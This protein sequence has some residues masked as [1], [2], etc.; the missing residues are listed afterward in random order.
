MRFEFRY[1]SSVFAIC[2]APGVNGL[3]R[4]IEAAPNA[5][6]LIPVEIIRF[7]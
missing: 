2:S 7:W 5:V 1:R 4:L 3:I 6:A